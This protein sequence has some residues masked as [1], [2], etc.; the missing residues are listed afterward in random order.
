ML[1]L[2]LAALAL[3]L[4]LEVP[5]L[6]PH[7]TFDYDAGNFARAW[8]RFD[9]A[10][11]RPQPPG[12]P[13]YVLL[14]RGVSRLTGAPQT[15][16][17]ALSLLF[18]IAGLLTFWKLARE[19]CGPKAGLAALILLAFSPL[20]RL[21]AVSQTT[22]AAD[23]FASS[24][25]GWLA[26]QV[27]RGRPLA[28]VPLGLA[29]GILT[30]IRSPGGFLLVPLAL[31]AL[32]RLFLRHRAAALAGAGALA[33]AILAWLAPVAESAGGWTQFRELSRENSM[34]AIR[35]TSVFFGGSPQLHYFMIRENGF[36]IVFGLLGF[37]TAL[38]FLRRPP[39]LRRLAA[40]LPKQDWLLFGAWLA[41]G[42]AT[43]F[44][45]HSN[46]PGYVL[47]LIPPLALLLAKALVWLEVRSW[48]AAVAA[49][50]LVAAVV[51][52]LP[53]ERWMRKDLPDIFY[54]ALRSTPSILGHVERNQER[55]AAGLEKISPSS[56]IEVFR[57]YNE[58]PNIS[59]VRV[60]FPKRIWL[61]RLSTDD[62]T[63]LHTMYRPA[64]EP[65]PEG[66]ARA[67]LCAGTGLPAWVAKQHPR[68]QRIT[69]GPHF[70]LYAELP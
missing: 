23:L 53:Y 66:L 65:V 15:G 33:G 67:W 45:L 1:R 39:R 35:T 69:E 12:F 36:F 2:G 10:A 70:Q 25:T 64:G 54:L 19:L 63:A 20:V 38:A 32:G 68:A 60:D 61:S 34:W 49:G 48:T 47:L 28:A 18:M 11:H 56:P 24:L 41:P 30:A 17:V 46:K 58:G 21:H 42:L 22:Y 6:H 44:L 55:F 31:T 7:Y 9:V 62:T 51:Q 57:T 8:E 29:L 16:M 37:L 4:A 13:L 14:L 52:I 50:L 43:V 59:T 5:Y 27:W 3:W 40:L 26:L